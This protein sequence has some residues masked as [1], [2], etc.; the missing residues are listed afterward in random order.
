MLTI[1]S[2]SIVDKKIRNIRKEL[3]EGKLDETESLADNDVMMLASAISYTPFRI[4]DY[5][6]GAYFLFVAAENE[7]ALL[8]R[9]VEAFGAAQPIPAQEVAPN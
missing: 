7:P 4:C 2:R 3:Q 9:C 1:V 6:E 8:S 5:Q